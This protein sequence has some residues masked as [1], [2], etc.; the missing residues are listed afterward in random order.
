MKQLE[1]ISNRYHQMVISGQQFLAEMQ[2]KT[3]DN[4]PYVT[5]FKSVQVIQLIK[6]TRN[7]LLL[8]SRMGCTI[9][10]VHLQ[11]FQSHQN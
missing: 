7:L 9:S 10:R 11:F 5:H 1:T 8:S 2:N 3:D 4:T 6:K